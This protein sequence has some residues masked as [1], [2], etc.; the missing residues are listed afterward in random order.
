MRHIRKIVGRYKYRFQA[1]LAQKLVKLD[2]DLGIRTADRKMLEQDIL[3]F[4]ARDDSYHNILFVG[5]EWYTRK[6]NKM[7]LQRN[8]WT[9]EMNPE[10]APYGGAQHIISKIETIGAHFEA[11]SLD[12]V[13]CNGVFGWGLD[14]KTD[15]EQAF[16]GIFKCLK[17]GG[18]FLLGWNDVPEHSPV[19]L[20]DLESLGKFKTWMFP[21]LAASNVL[22]SEATQHRYNFYQKPLVQVFF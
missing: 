10:L 2:I 12:L 14:Q 16:A 20:A 9:M 6:Y 11:N 8:Y 5:C 17:P 1:A 3:P 15:I 18:V 7:F 22:A 21:P 13:V 19:P 4:F